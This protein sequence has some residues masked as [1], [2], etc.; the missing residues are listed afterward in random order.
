MTP[1]RRADG[2]RHHAILDRGRSLDDDST[3]QVAGDEVAH[4][5]RAATR[6]GNHGSNRVA[7]RAVNNNPSGEVASAVLPV[8]IRTDRVADH[9]IAS[10]RSGEGD[11]GPV[12]AGDQVSKTRSHAADRVARCA[13]VDEH[14][15]SFVA[16]DR[17]AALPRGSTPMKALMIRLPLDTPVT[18]P[19]M[20]SVVI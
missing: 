2:V 18:V 19:E 7:R 9:E 14:S 12:V 13:A 10:G 17:R 11:A 16:D 20:M 6:A 3:P 5:D 4:G 15:A 8:E 1:D